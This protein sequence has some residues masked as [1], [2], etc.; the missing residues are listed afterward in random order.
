MLRISCLESSAPQAL[1][2]ETQ[3][4]AARIG[5]HQKEYAANYELGNVLYFF[6]DYHFNKGS[7]IAYKYFYIYFHIKLYY[8]RYSCSLFQKKS[9]KA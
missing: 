6:H 7:R 9:W 4:G 2:S 3:H 1:V 8:I 5:I